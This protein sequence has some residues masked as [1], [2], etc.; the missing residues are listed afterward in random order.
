MSGCNEWRSKLLKGKFPVY[1]FKSPLLGLQTYVH[2]VC[3]HDLGEERLRCVGEI[4]MVLKFS[5]INP[6]FTQ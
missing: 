2:Y 3:E 6:T 1:Y 5:S 4:Y